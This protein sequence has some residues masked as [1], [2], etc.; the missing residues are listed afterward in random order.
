MFSYISLNEVLKNILLKYLSYLHEM[1]FYVSIMLFRVCWSSQ[2]LM[3][4]ENWVLLLM[5]L[6]LPLTIWLSLVLTSLVVSVWSLSPESLVVADL[7]GD[8]LPLLQQS[9]GSPA[10]C[11]VV[12]GV[13][14]LICPCRGADLKGFFGDLK[15]R[16]RNTSL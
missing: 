3:W 4:W 14:R 11:G 8:L 16:I 2:G 5:F 15:N 7:L 12:R 10:H 9:S 13:D 6:C 1:G